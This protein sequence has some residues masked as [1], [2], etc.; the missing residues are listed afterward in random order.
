MGKKELNKDLL[1]VFEKPWKQ[2]DKIRA[3]ISEK[4]G[5]YRATDADVARELNVAPTT[6]GNMKARNIVIFTLYV[7]KWAMDNNLEPMQFIKKQRG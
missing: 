3:F 2:V 1:N 7:L 4:N 6:V 5:I